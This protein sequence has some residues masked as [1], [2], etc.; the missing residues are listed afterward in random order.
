MY[1]ETFPHHIEHEMMYFIDGRNI[2]ASQLKEYRRA[3]ESAQKEAAAREKPHE[4]L[5]CPIRRSKCREDCALYSSDGCAVLRIAN[6]SDVA[7]EAP[8]AVH[9]CPF[10]PGATICADNC[11]LKTGGSC[12]LAVIANNRKELPNE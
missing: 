12:A 7:Q 10:Y 11:A 5:S 6:A 1:N 8:R 4:P 9:S 3:K 2:P